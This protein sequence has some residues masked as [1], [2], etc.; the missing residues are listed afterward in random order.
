[1]K[2]TIDTAAL[3]LFDKDPDL[4]RKYL[5]DYCIDNAKRVVKQWRNLADYLIVKYDDGYVNE[6]E[7]AGEVG[8]LKW[9]L[10]KVGYKKEPTSFE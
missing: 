1:M 8:Y 4:A 9:W 5:T 6:T 7:I 3:E 10:I 2:P